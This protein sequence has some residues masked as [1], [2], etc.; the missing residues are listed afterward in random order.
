MLPFILVGV[1]LLYAWAVRKVHAGG[2]QLQR[3]R[4]AWGI[5]WWKG[6]AKAFA[7]SRIWCGG[8]WYGFRLGPF[9]LAVEP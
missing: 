4:V 7:Y 6:S 8:Y 5:G 1:V 9:W 2:M 3:G